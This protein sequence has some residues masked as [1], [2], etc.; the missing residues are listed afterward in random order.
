MSCNYFLYYVVTQIVKSAVIDNWSSRFLLRNCVNIDSDLKCLYL[1][2]VEIKLSNVCLHKVLSSGPVSGWRLF[3]Q[4]KVE[5]PKPGKDSVLDVVPF[6]SYPRKDSCRLESIAWH[7]WQQIYFP[8][9]ALLWLIL[10]PV[11]SPECT[12]RWKEVQVHTLGAKGSQPD[13][14]LW[15]HKYRTW[16]RLRWILLENHSSRKRFQRKPGPAPNQGQPPSGAPI[17]PRL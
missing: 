2:N 17:D 8:N 1:K 15:Q 5:Q 14:S 16:S 4:A 10:K 11:P 13:I 3:R 12:P 9:Y 7:F 6:T